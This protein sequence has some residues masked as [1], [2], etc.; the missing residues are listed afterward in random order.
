MGQCPQNSQ[1]LLASLTVY[2]LPHHPPHLELHYSLGRDLNWFQGLWI[3][4]SS[5]RRL[6]DLKDSE[7]AELQAVALG[8]FGDYLI[9]ELLHHGLDGNMLALSP[10]CDLFDELFLGYC[11]HQPTLE[12]DCRRLHGTVYTEDCIKAN[13]VWAG[14]T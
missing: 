8:G 5:W 11:C 10:L 3:L 12:P 13:R 1:L 7:I 9:E 6:P 14:S 2:P 4:C